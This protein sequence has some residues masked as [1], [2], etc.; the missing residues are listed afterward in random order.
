MEITPASLTRRNMYKLLTGT[1]VPRPIAWVS[2]VN[3]AGQANLAPFSFFNAVSA[4]PPTLLFCPGLRRTD[5]QEKDTLRNIRAT[6]E[7]VVNI[8]TEALAAAMNI[9]ATELP[10][11]IDEFNLAGLA[12][13]PARVVRPPRVAASP[14]HYECRVLQIVDLGGEGAAN[15]SASVV[16]GQVLHLHVSDEVLL[17]EY[18]IDFDRLLA[19]GRLAGNGY[20]RTRDRFQLI[21]PASQVQP[22]AG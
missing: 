6:G 15:G 22:P 5:G 19:I 7:F 13:T 18:K 12:T 16:I 17:P 1:I 2:T 8:V 20:C 4:S 10:A 14:V 11:E 3:E 21:R 9:T